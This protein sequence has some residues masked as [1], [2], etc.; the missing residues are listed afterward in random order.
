MSSQTLTPHLWPDN[1]ITPAA[2]PDWTFNGQPTRELTHC[3]HDYPARMIP[4]IAGKLLDTFGREAALLF[5]PYCGSGTT[6]V[7]AMLRGINVAGTD[8]NPLARLIAQAKLAMPD[9]EKI[10]RHIVALQKFLFRAPQSK[11]SVVTEIH[12]ISRLNFWFKPEVIEKL[13]RLK[14]FIDGLNEQGVRLFFQVAF[15][16]TVRESSNTRNEE[17]KLYRYEAERLEKFKP[18]VYGIM[19]SK[20]RR[21]RVGLSE[22]LSALHHIKPKPR[23]TIYDFNT[24]SGIPAGTLTSESVD[25]V[26]TSPPYGDSHTTVAYGQYS[27][28]SAAWL[29]LPK[30]EKTDRK[31]MGGSN[32]AKAMPRFPCQTL[33]EALSRIGQCDEKRALEVATF[34]ADLDQSISHVAAVVRVGGC[35]CYVVGNR[36]VKGVVLPTNEAVRRFFEQFG[37]KHLDTFH[38]VIPNKRMPLRNSPTNAAGSVDDTITSEQIIV[39]RKRC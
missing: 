21:N 34:Y 2:Q 30:P 16:E 28:L 13:S 17:F 36:K 8:L 14:T 35:V 19:L 29:G 6:L 31:L 24:V 20:L 18:D 10:D 11:T 7:E 38:R 3:Y 27:R 39:L 33:N 26:I 15:S 4:Q 22:F 12:G 1:E 9:A 23:T 5:D 37:F 25:I 32:L